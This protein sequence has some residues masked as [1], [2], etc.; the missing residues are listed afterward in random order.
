M[1]KVQSCFSK[2][3]WAGLVFSPP[4]QS[5]PK[6]RKWG[7]LQMGRSHCIHCLPDGILILHITP[8]CH[9]WI[10]PS[11]ARIQYFIT[12]YFQ[13]CYWRIT[14]TAKSSHFL[15]A[16]FLPQQSRNYS[17]YLLLWK[18]TGDAWYLLC[19]LYLWKA[20]RFYLWM[21]R[22]MN[23][24]HRMLCTVRPLQTLHLT[25]WQ[26]LLKGR[27]LSDHY[28]GHIESQNLVKA[29]QISED[30]RKGGLRI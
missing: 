22:L 12:R 30:R 2:R 26:V 15:C 18:E 16:L 23:R 28:I 1:H 3:Q 8:R 19:V 29:M 10:Q 5:G 11:K 21:E 27:D 20:A 14:S 6:Q 13:L 4:A 9:S 24:K 7:S 25:I 17:T